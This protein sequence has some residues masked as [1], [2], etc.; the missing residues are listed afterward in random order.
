MIFDELANL[1][2]SAGALAESWI[3]PAVR[4]GVTGLAR[5]GKTVFITALVHN[6]IHGGRMPF[7][8]AMAEGRILRAYLE[9]QPD[10]SVP[11]F[12]YEDHI[13]ALIGR[14]PRWPDG[15]RHISQLRLTLDY[16]P[17]AFLRRQLGNATVHI[18]I[19]DYPG[20]WL[21]DLPLLR[22]SYEE[23]SAEA[24]TLS[25]ATGRRHLATEWLSFL[26]SLSTGTPADEQVA[27]RGARLFAAYLRA[28]RADPTQL[29][30][31]TP[32][33]MLMPGD[34]EDSPALTFMPL[35][36]VGATAAPRSRDSLHAM[37]ARRFEAYKTYVVK[38]FFRDHFV[39]LERQIVLADVLGAMN[40]GAAAMAELERALTAILAC[41]RPGA[42]SW[43]SPIIGKRIDRILFAATK[44]DHVHHT[45]HDR[46]EA[47]MRLLV[48]KAAARAEFSGATVRALAMAAV[49]STREVQA[50]ESGEA[51]GCIAGTPLAG[52][53]LDGRLFGGGEEIALFPGDL[54]ASP[55]D[56]LTD[57]LRFLRFA[58]P[59]LQ[60]GGFGSGV[61]LPHIRL[62]HAIQFL[63]GDKFA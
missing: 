25:R 60:S 3:N 47:I 49:R 61:L 10:D 20:E 33:R 9:P 41:Y 48:E 23:W 57:A 8:G 29:S 46:L 30:T 53:R 31:L 26:G 45:S 50:K 58:P 21:L 39:K 32:G 54:P 62:D 43:L 59:P 1:R 24:L 11:R 34:L 56:Q 40:A 14:P 15:T 28:C 2:R 42:N 55:A 4:L 63:I 51:L 36:P 44:A 5:S 27:I 6:L 16:E 52:E 12:A 17:V 7:F 19:V 38:P 35:D 37:M 13:A 18:D 22:Q